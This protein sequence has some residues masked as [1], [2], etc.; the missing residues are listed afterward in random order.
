MNFAGH[1]YQQSSS[2]R[3][4]AELVRVGHSWYV[5]PTGGRR[6]SVQMKSVEPAV[7][8]VPQRI[9]LEDGRT[10]EP[11]AVIADVVLEEYFGHLHTTINRLSRITL[12]SAILLVLLVVAS[13]A[14]YR[15]LL[16]IAADA[17]VAHTPRALD[18]AVGSAA[19]TLMDKGE[20]QPSELAPSVQMAI[21]E[22]YAALL[23]ET[24]LTPEPVLHFRSSKRFGA[25]AFVLAGGPI[26]ITDA[27]VE[28]LE[29]ERLINA[30]LAHELGHI[31]ERHVIRNIA[32]AIGVIVLTTAVVGADEAVIEELAVLVVGLSQA[33]YSRGFEAKAD[34]YAAALL[35]STGNSATDL[36]DSFRL[37]LEEYAGAGGGSWWNSHPALEERIKA[38]E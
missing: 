19:F 16:P 8:R 25:N 2:Q 3:E 21:A 9:H 10:F 5:A 14:G 28:L 27:M 20:L 37:L 18:R 17:L 23:S 6:E 31:E 29:D 11:H 7:G 4:A 36:A 35:E 34:A 13:L 15:L 38:L 1:L 33:A 32:R 22:N 24:G 30:V 26:V 12:F